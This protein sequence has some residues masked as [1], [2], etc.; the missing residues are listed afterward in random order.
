MPTCKRGHEFRGDE[1]Y[2]ARSGRCPVC[3][4]GYGRTY[5]RSPKGRAALE[6]YFATENGRSVKK[7]CNARTNARRIRVGSVYLGSCGFTV[8]EME[9]LLNGPTD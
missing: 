4:R 7:E 1:N 3:Q 5:R 8:P 6:R 2:R 9:A